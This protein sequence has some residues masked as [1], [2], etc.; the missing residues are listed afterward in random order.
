[1][2]RL[3]GITTALLSLA[4][5]LGAL[6]V[7]LIFVVHVPVDARL[8]PRTYVQAYGA[9]DLVVAGAGLVAAALVAL[10]LYRRREE[11]PPTAGPAAWAVSIATLVVG[12]L[13]IVTISPDLLLVGVF[14][15]GAC[16]SRSAR[17]PAVTDPALPPAPRT[18]AVP[19]RASS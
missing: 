5:L 3:G 16:L 12:L 19:H 9:A 2:K 10:L 14:L 11:D 17:R 7:A 6:N 18:V 8:R 15:I 1:M 13:G 4:L